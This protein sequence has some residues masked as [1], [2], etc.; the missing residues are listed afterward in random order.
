L[1]K[2]RPKN[3]RSCGRPEIPPFQLQDVKDRQHDDTPE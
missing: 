1:Q 3:K 2:P